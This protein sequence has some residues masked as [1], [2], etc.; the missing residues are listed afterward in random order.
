[1]NTSHIAAASLENFVKAS[2]TLMTTLFLWTCMH[3]LT[4]SFNMRHFSWVLSITGYIFAITVFCYY[5]IVE[6]SGWYNL[7]GLYALCAC[8][9]AMF[10]TLPLLILYF[11][12]DQSS[13]DKQTQQQSSK[14]SK[15]VEDE[16]WEPASVDDLH[17]GE[18][19]LEN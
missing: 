4:K 7:N 18:F 9:I 8:S 2:F 14:T 1:M 12:G 10:A 17:S 16:N 3:I 6:K 5:G 11:K 15:P 13:A 19:E